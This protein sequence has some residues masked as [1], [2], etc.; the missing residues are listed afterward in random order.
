MFRTATHATDIEPLQIPFTQNDARLRTL[1]W[2]MSLES[3]IC[4]ARQDLTAQTGLVCSVAMAAT[5]AKRRMAEE[6]PVQELWLSY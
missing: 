5:P 6:Q 1:L 3:K 4:L 2:K